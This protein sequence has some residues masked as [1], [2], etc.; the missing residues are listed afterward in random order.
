[1]AFRQIHEVLQM[2]PLPQQ[3][4]PRGGKVAG[5]KRENSGDDFDGENIKREKLE[6]DA[7]NEINHE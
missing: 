2:D 6:E 4:F 3:R 5:R 1:M 7:D